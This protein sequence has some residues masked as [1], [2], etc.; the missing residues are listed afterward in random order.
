MNLTDAGLA[1]AA[2]SFQRTAR[3]DGG[4]ALTVLVRMS[5]EKDTWGAVVLPLTPGQINP[6]D[7]SDYQGVQFEARG[8]GGYTLE[9]DTKR[10]RAYD[11]PS[12]P[13]EAHAAW[14]QIRIPFAELGSESPADATALLFRVRRQAGEQAWLELDNIRLY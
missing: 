9:I 3:P 6:A 14:K 5:Q 2:M 11:Y 1:H 8:E 12:A 4:H 10:S 7:L 13:F